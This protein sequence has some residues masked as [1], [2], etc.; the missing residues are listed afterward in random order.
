MPLSTRERKF[1]LCLRETPA[2]DGGASH[3]GVHPGH[4]NSPAPGREV[5]AKSNPPDR[6]GVVFM[7]DEWSQSNACS[8]GEPQFSAKL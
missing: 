8:F 1:P 6:R 2:P 4:F 3:R 5:A 7:S